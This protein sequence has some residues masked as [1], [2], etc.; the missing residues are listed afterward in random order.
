MKKMFMKSGLRPNIPQVASIQI[1]TISR[2][3]IRSSTERGSMKERPTRSPL[4]GEG[5][6]IRSIERR[7]V[8][9]VVELGEAARRRGKTRVGGDV[10]DPLAV[11]EQPAVVAQRLQ[12][13]AAGANAHPAFLRL[14]LGVE[15]RVVPKDAVLVERDAAVRA[16]DRRRC[17]GE[18]RPGHAAQRPAGASARAAPWRGERRS[19]DPPRFERATDRDRSVPHRRD[20]RAGPIALQHPFEIAEVFWGPR[21]HKVGGAGARFRV[22]G[23]RNRGCWRS[24]GACRELRPRNRRSSVAA[25]APTTGPPRRPAPSRDER[26]DRAGCWRSDR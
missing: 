4:V 7:V 20:V 15:L 26:R 11:D 14:C 2:R 10:L 21:F 12:Q 16:R 6:V 17:G 18:R 25:G 13:L 8:L 24:D 3:R 5:K 22:A 1:F 19:A 9:H 23:L